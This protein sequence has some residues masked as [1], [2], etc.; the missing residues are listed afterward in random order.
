MRA[1]H[2]G[3]STVCRRLTGLLGFPRNDT[4]AEPLSDGEDRRILRE[5]EV[6]AIG[7][8]KEN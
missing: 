6:L 4:C 3:A 8:R 2:A 5:D 1:I 7:S